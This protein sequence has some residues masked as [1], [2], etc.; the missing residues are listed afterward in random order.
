MDWEKINTNLAETIS[1][2]INNDKNLEEL[3]KWN[4]EQ[5]HNLNSHKHLIKLIDFKDIYKQRAHGSLC[6]V[7]SSE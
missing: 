4:D 2:G 1:Q 5:Q 7:P 3:Q 6:L